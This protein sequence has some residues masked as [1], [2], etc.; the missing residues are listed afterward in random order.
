MELARPAL[1]RFSAQLADHEQEQLFRAYNLRGQRRT[2]LTTLVVL[3]LANA[4]TFGY[5]AISSVAPV[6]ALRIGGQVAGTLAGA[7][8]VVGLARGKR[9]TSML[10]LVSGAL[11]TMTGLIVT[12]MAEGTGMG[13]RGA[14]L[15]IGGIAVIYL[16]VPLHLSAVT[17]FALLYSAAT[18]PFWLAAIRPDSDV[19]VA[20]TAMAIVLAHVLSFSEARRAQTERRV[21][22]AQRETLLALSSIDPLTGLMNRRAVDT[23]LAAA[24]DARRR[25]GAPISVVMVD[26]DHFKNLNDTQGHIAGDHA[27]RLVADVIRGAM[28]MVPGQVAARY[29]G[30][31]FVC[32]L[33]GLD[34]AAAAVTAGRILA[35]VRRIGIP[36]TAS[37]SGHT[38]LT[39]S[40]G[41]ASADDLTGLAAGD[42]AAAEALV[43]AA[44]RQLYRAKADGRNCVRAASV[45]LSTPRMTAEP[46]SASAPAQA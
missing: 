17:G 38:I 43:G 35:A 2:A 28:P 46:P 23:E 30:E 29:G 12:M 31:E 18:I 44:D 11:V 24:L 19:D 7:A 1:T 37:D 6:S 45:P 4:L 34:G 9:H 32:L 20:Y 40:A 42:A 8:V 13:F 41:V 5:T 27:L 3:L 14:I 39:V 16:I 21:L 15:I 33:P 22:Y 25:T 26:I 10:W 36:L